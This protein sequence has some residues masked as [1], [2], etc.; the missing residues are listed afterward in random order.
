MHDLLEAS[1]G[2]LYILGVFWRPNGVVCRGDHTLLFYT[3]YDAVAR[4][5]CRGAI[6]VR[7]RSGSGDGVQLLQHY[8][9]LQ[10]QIP[11]PSSSYQRDV[12]WPQGAR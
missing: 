10:T 9:I 12:S 7:T 4:C 1:G 11:A 2:Q 5:C 3:P 6:T 8:V